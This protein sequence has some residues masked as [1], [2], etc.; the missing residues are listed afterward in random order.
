MDITIIEIKEGKK[1][2]FDKNI[3]KTLDYMRKRYSKLSKTK[4][5]KRDYKANVSLNTNEKTS[6]NMSTIV[7]VHMFGNP[8]DGIWDENKL[9]LI[10]ET[11][12][13]YEKN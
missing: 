7:Y 6:L 1:E 12:K 10:E 9:K 11:L 3:K 8:K 5:K 13:K 4:E 2:K